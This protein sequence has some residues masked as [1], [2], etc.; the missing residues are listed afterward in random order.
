L[1]NYKRLIPLYTLKGTKILEPG[2]SN[3]AKYSDKVGTFGCSKI[4]S[5]DVNA[6]PLGH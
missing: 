5:P 4:S 2:D 6:V 3:Y 1:I